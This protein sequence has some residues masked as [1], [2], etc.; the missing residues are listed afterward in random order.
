MLEDTEVKAI[1]PDALAPAEIEAKAETL[2]V[3]K[4]TM[5]LGKMFVLAIMAGMF[6]ALGATLFSLVQGD[7]EMWFGIKRVFGAMMFSLGLIMTVCCGAELFTGNCLMICGAGS[8]KIQWS[9]LIRNWVCVYIGNLVGSLIIVLLVYLANMAAMNGGAVG[10]A[11]VATAAGKITP[12]ALTL[13]AKGILCNTL[14][15]LAVWMSFGARTLVDKIF[16]VIMPV[17]AFVA[18]GF[19][20][21]IANMF[22]LPMGLLAQQAG[23]GSA[24]A[25]VITLGG[26]GYNL[27]FVTLGNIVG[28]AI[29]VGLSYWYVYHKKN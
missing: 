1:K 8:K 5:G 26:I 29:L 2:A 25:T 18:C 6:I 20:H 19:E 4:A 12:D 9:G 16:C 28:G 3:G 23:F 27:L 17:T 11:M 21:S 24:T 10:D 13:F 15:C 7:T 22:F 14:V